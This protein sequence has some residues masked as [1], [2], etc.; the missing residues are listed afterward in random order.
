MALGGVWARLSAWLVAQ[1]C[2][3]S[4]VAGA[5][6]GSVTIAAVIGPV[7]RL[8][9]QGRRRVLCAAD[10]YAVGSS[11]ASPSSSVDT[12]KSDSPCS[13][14]LGGSRGMAECIWMQN[15]LLLRLL[16]HL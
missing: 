16:L 2:P 9:W 13:F 10:T 8:L 7:A 1:E 4:G 12:P 5:Y 15:V 3:R 6:L 14:L 11:D